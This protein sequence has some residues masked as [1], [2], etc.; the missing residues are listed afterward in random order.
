LNWQGQPQLQLQAMNSTPCMRHSAMAM[1]NLFTLA[2][3]MTVAIT[4]SP[5]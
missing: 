1:I 2:G 3:E 4:P 5:H